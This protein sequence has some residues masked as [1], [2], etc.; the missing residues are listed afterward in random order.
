[1]ATHATLSLQKL[2]LAQSNAV[3]AKGW[4]WGGGG[5]RGALTMFF[6]PHLE[7]VACVYTNSEIPQ[8]HVPKYGR[9][10]SSHFLPA[11]LIEDTGWGFNKGNG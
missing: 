3:G 7:M 11:G 9:L 6:S 10:Q 5:V 8:S 1:M 2:G 4:G